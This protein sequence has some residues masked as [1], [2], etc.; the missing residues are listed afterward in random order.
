MN[1]QGRFVLDIELWCNDCN[2]RHGPYGC[3]DLDCVHCYEQTG[4]T[5]TGDTPDDTHNTL[6]TLLGA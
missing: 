6:D 2:T 1:K 3:D 5:P 4:H